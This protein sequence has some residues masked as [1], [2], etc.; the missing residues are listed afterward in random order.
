[1][2]LFQASVAPAIAKLAPRR[3]HQIR[4]QTFGPTE[5]ELAERLEPF[6]G[7]DGVTF[8]YRV[9]FPEIE[10][11][12]HARANDEAEAE[13]LARSVVDRVRD[14]LGDAVYGERDATFP[15]VIG[16]AFRNK[17]RT[18]ALAE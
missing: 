10:V 6:E 4:L 8:G 12:V 2:A 9:S 15:G 14:R 1:R 17:G 7:Q 13:A 3:T 18:L 5:S 11:K 16:K